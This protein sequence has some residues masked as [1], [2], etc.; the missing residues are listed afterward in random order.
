VALSGCDQASLFDRFIPKDEVR[1]AQDFVAKLAAHDYPAIEAA[2]DPALRTPDLRGKLEQMAGILPAGD[3]KSVHT[4]GAFTL[5]TAT[6]TT[7]SL[8]LEYEYP[9]AWIL[10]ALVL[11]KRDGQLTLKSFQ[12]VPR[13]Q[14]MEVENRF[15]LDGKAPLH[16][17]V[18][19]LAVAIPLF[20]LFALV[21]CVRTKFEKRKWLWVL[22][23][24]VGLVQFQFNWTSGDWQIR[25]VS[26]ALFGA[27]FVRSGP[28][29]PWIF[30]L[31]VPVGAIVFLLR[32]RAQRLAGAAS[33]E[34]ES[35]AQA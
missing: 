9:T 28:V 14:S 32:R 3:P 31:A 24:A 17:V 13:S 30:T 29:G 35:A 25:P 10:A 33:A 12:L 15:T 27:G 26:F 20:I 5:T 21:L 16:Y 6:A 34:P 8:T 22:F 1:Q 23:V 7:F 4:V 2:L 11:E 19:A 18:L